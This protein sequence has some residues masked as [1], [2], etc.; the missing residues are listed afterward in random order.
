MKEAANSAGMSHSHML[1]K[2]EA[3]WRVSSVGSFVANDKWEPIDKPTQETN[4]TTA[5]YVARHS[6]A[7]HSVIPT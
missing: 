5:S 4:L 2:A 1:R 6:L 7:V 3:L